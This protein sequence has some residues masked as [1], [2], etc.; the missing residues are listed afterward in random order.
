MS[1]RLSN[2]RVTMD[3][4]RS[5]QKIGS[6][7][8]KN[9]IIGQISAAAAADITDG[10]YVSDVPRTN[11]EINELFGEDS[12]LALLARSYREE[13]EYTNLSAIALEDNV[14]ATAGAATITLAGAATRDGTLS[15]TVV[16]EYHY[17]F[18]IEVLSGDDSTDFLDK[19]DAAITA[20]GAAP[21]TFAI[22][23][24]EGTF[25]A[26]NGGS[27]CNNWPIKV[28]GR[29]PGLTY[30]LTGWSGGATDPDLSTLFDEVQDIR[31]Q[32]IVWPESYATSTIKNFIDPRKNVDNDVKDGCA[33]MYLNS[34]FVN[35][36]TAALG[37]NSSEI[38]VLTNKPVTEL[39]WI[40]PLLPTAPDMLAAYYIA[41]R[42]LR[43]EDGVSVSDKVST[44]ASGDQFG[45]SHM[46]SLPFFNTPLRFAGLPRASGGY[47]LAEQLELEHAGVSVVGANRSNTGVVLGQMVTT[48]QKDPAGN[49]DATWQYRNWR[50]THGAI[51]EHMVLRNKVRW[52][53]SR[54]SVGAP[55]ANRDYATEESVRAFQSEIVGELAEMSLAV[56][57]PAAREFFEKNLVVTLVPGERR[58]LIYALVPM[59]SQLGEIIGTVQYSFTTG[60]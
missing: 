28:K 59:V 4:I 50:D 48:F 43:I 25:T 29:V 42:S 40:G 38:D 46:H 11:E 33:A 2:P 1:N 7:D 58:V 49:D 27:I 13:N 22:D 53:Q 39:D 16:S 34:T 6:D 8:I 60:S 37:L 15:V 17:T 31:F 54:M 20:R 10:M 32:G 21:F 44:V 9:L 52:S 3:I 30:V 45:G 24:A 19:L 5:P 23:G 55:V 35:S 14:G 36:K 26:V 56:K 51:R 41:I 18:E 12:H 57:G 47:S